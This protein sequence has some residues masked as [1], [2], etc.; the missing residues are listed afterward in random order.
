MAYRDD[1][2]LDGGAAQLRRLPKGFP[3]PDDGADLKTLFR[4]LSDDASQL[5]HDELALARM[6]FRDIAEAFSSDMQ[7]ATR[8]L[9]TNI[10]KVGVAL[11]L[12]LLAGLAL[13]AGAVIGVGLLL[14]GAYWAGGLIVGGLLL[15][16]AAAFG[17]SAA[18]DLRDSDALRLENARRTMDRDTDVLQD[19]IRD[20]GRFARDE[21]RDF[22][23]HAKPPS[24]TPPRPRTRH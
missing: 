5:A 17:M 1:D 3:E 8:T 10:T 18:T 14:G 15:V 6:E 19:E 16:A 20:T 7:N 22:K 11:S 2:F 23:Y 9:V 21:A 13:T 24:K 4:Q 12:A